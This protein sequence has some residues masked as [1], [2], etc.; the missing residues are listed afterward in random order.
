MDPVELYSL[1]SGRINFHIL[2]TRISYTATVFG[3]SFRIACFTDTPNSFATMFSASKTCFPKHFYGYLSLQGQPI[4][5][6]RARFPTSGYLEGQFIQDSHW[7]VVIFL[8]LDLSV[9]TKTSVPLWTVLLPIREMD[10]CS[11]YDVMI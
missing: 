8:V 2:M 10:R 9:E 4:C 3:D 11:M 5:L 6:P 1:D 7:S